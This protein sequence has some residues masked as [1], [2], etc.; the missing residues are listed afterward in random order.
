MI[1]LILISIVSAWLNVINIRARKDTTKL[2]G[3]LIRKGSVSKNE[4]EALKRKANDSF[5]NEESR[6]KWSVN[7]LGFQA[8]VIMITLIVVVYF[9]SHLESG[10]GPRLDIEGASGIQTNK[11]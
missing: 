2:T 5:V 7:L 8:V 1:P 4:A 3:Q 10:P 11:D 9:P 6:E